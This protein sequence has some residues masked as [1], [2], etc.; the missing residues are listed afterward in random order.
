MAVV[1]RPAGR[2]GSAAGRRVLLA[3]HRAVYDL[4]L[5]KSRGS[6]GIEGVR[7]RIL[8]DFSGS[9]CEGYELQ[10][11]QVSELDFGEG[12]AALSDLRSTT[13][14]DGDAK[15]FRFNSENLLNERRTD[16]VDGHAERNEPGRGGQPEQAERKNFTVPATAVFP[17]EHM[18][19]IIA[20][21]R[22]GKI[23]PRISG[24]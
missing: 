14:E 20:A 12:K 23:D 9:A 16:V 7:G 5:A 21:A 6:R 3:P 11:R 18:R 4:K 1:W 19:R 2:G 10:F 17:T 24:L 13:W 8:Y 22:E 15:K